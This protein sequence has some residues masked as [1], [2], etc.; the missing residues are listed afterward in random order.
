MASS[1]K[2]TVVERCPVSPPRRSV[3]PTSLPLTFF[4]IPWLLFSP[5]QPLFFY[6]FPTS[7]AHFTQTILPNLKHTLSLTLQHFFPLA[8]KLV[9]PPLSAGP[10]IQY[11]EG[12]FI[13]FTI[14]EAA[15]A[16]G[17]FKH[18]AGNHRKMARDFHGLVPVL[19]TGVG[20]KQPLLAIQITVFPE[21]G[22]CIG[23]TLRHEVADGRTFNN[24]LRAWAS[25]TKNGENMEVDW[26]VAFHDRSV[27]RDPVD[28][29]YWNQMKQIPLQSS[30]F[31][32]P[33][34]RVRATYVFNQ[35]E[36]KKLKDLV[37]AR[38]P[39][40]VHASSFVVT[41]AYVWNCLAK[42]LIAGEEEKV[43]D[44]E[45]EFFLFAVDSRARLD[46]PVPGNYFGNCLSYGLGKNRHQ[47]LVGNEG[48]FMAAQAIAE[49]IKNRVNDK[50]KILKGA[51][52]W[53]TE[54]GSVVQK[55]MFAVSGSTRVDLYSADFGWGK[56]R[57]LETLSIDGEKYAMSLS[58][59]GD[60][61]GGLEVGLS[62]PKVKMDAF[63]AIFADGIKGL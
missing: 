34:K 9:M 27:I 48:F 39:G 53:V 32:L 54:I 16:A 59:S 30:S 13:F 41:A 4:D 28:S 6:D 62:L 55:R 17:D 43:D 33:T 7:A 61:E 57:K 35:S 24:F 18:L 14:A 20:P 2:V 52:N 29:I 47:E 49:E 60:S 56:A 11:T 46:P 19:R 26:L 36:I 38:I 23:F 42:S 5:T 3:L 63:A 21:A 25:L 40:L 45:L 12:D 8:G 10:Q 31:P 1:I 58:K 44:D 50:E 15:A 51:E 22:I 37:L